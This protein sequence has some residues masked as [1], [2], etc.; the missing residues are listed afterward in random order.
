MSREKK[1]EKMSRES[2][3]I[4]LL[5]LVAL[6]PAARSLED[7][8]AVLDVGGETL[9]LTHD[10]MVEA[11]HWLPNAD[12]A[13]VAWKLLAS[14]LSDLAAKGAEP[15]AVLLGFQLADSADSADSDWNRRFVQGLSEALKHFGV[16]LL[17]GDT[18]RGG[19]EVRSAPDQSAPERNTG[20]V[21]GRVIGMTAVGRS[22]CC[23]VPSRAGARAGDGV[24]ITGSIG[25][26]GA[27]LALLQRGL[28]TPQSLLDACNRPMPRLA[29]GRLLA[30][31]A[32]AM[33]DVSDGLLLDA[34][35]L[36]FASGIAIDL[37]L[38]RVP[39]SAD[40]LA[41][42]REAH[43][44]RG[45]GEALE[46]HEARLFAATAGE[47]YELLFVLSSEDD[48]PVPAR[49][50]GRCRSGEG[51]HLNVGGVACA[52]PASLGYEH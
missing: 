13:D 42:R 15:L 29:E 34:Q 11:V 23:P 27:G 44:A 39:V 48:C 35:R 17:G 14:N 52:L 16:A 6:H 31:L 43:E 10:M 19:P 28:S 41:V 3:F 37:D 45:G 22:T 47:D 51:L 8:A 5:R 24:W 33:M 2:E 49:L 9:I 18:V 21:V 50:I 30:P 32:K 26:A 20:R 36:A 25:D 12:P 46:T 1:R 40:F 7:D 38:A 4:D